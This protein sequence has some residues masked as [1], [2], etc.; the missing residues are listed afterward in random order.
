MKKIKT[1]KPKKEKVKPCDGLGRHEI[2]K[3]R[4]ALRQVWHRSMARRLT[5]KRSS[6]EGDLYKCETCSNIVPVIKIDHITP[7]GDVDGGYIE[8][9]F[10]HS[11][12]LQAMCKKCHNEKTK[13]ERR[14]SKEKK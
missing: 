11:Y 2:A 8:R 12:K 1:P 13:E 14:L 10:C 4:S 7:C 9:L 5:V 6:V 3:I